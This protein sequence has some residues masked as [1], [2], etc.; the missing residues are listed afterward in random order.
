MRLKIPH[1]VSLWQ[2]SS[3]DCLIFTTC[4]TLSPLDCLSIG[5]FIYATSSGN[6]RV[7][8]TSCSID[9]QGA[10]FLFLGVCKYLNT[11]STVTTQLD[12]S[13]RGNDI[14]EEGAHHIAELLSN[15]NVVYN[16]NLSG[17]RVGA[18]G[19]KSLCNALV[20]N[21]S[22]TELDLS[23]CSIVVSEDNSPVLTEMLRRNNALKVL[24]L[25]WNSVTDS[26][27]H[28]IATGLKDNKSLRELNLTKCG[29]TD[30][31]VE[32]LST[33]LNDYIEELRLYGNEVI[34][35]SGLK[36]LA[37][38]LIIP[39]RLRLSSSIAVSEHDNLMHSLNICSCKADPCHLSLSLTPCSG[40]FICD[41]HLIMNTRNTTSNIKV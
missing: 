15:T 36:T 39:A 22:L 33:G 13:L 38:H 14:H 23:M 25:S 4:T 5:Y 16:L 10:L 26:A 11:H 2:N 21:T 35:I 34:T 29:L 17:N 19:L 7:S 1:S 37:S 24:S 3:M 9:D 20:T 12:M 32:S 8:L 27:C 18:E 6:F 28:Y 40:N 41:V 31:E 30:R